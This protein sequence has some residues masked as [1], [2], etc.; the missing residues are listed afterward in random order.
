MIDRQG[1]IGYWD[2][3]ECTITLDSVPIQTIQLKEKKE[4]SAWIDLTET[5]EILRQYFKSVRWKNQDV[6]ET[7]VRKCLKEEL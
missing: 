7:W 4:T 3:S 5:S 6:N 2:W 1:A